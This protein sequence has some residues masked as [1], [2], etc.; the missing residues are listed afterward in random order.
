MREE[1]RQTTNASAASE[2]RLL[3][4]GDET[5]VKSNNNQGARAGAM[6]AFKEESGRMHLQT[7][8]IKVSIVLHL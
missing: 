7:L 8:S 4:C 3:P 5:K 1:I 2:L 6:T